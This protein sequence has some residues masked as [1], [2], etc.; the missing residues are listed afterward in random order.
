[1]VP[2]LPLQQQHD[3]G[4][5]SAFPHKKDSPQKNSLMPGAVVSMVKAMAWFFF[6][7]V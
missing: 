2:L 7:Y 5:I 4:M 3:A 6:V 1:M